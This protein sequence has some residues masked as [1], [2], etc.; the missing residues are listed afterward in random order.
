MGAPQANWPRIWAKT[1]EVF[2]SQFLLISYIVATVIALAWPVPGR[3]VV[4]VSVRCRWLSQFV[5]LLKMP[6]CCNHV[7]LPRLLA[8]PALRPLRMWHVQPSRSVLLAQLNAVFGERTQLCGLQD[9][10]HHDR[11]VHQCI[12]SGTCSDLMGSSN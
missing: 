1:K 7:Q 5:R 10:E 3:A 12:A 11:C 4:S 2:V 6:G 8:V 9:T